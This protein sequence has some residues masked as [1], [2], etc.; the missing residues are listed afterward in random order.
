MSGEC[1]ADP[2]C[3]LLLTIHRVHGVETGRTCIDQCGPKSHS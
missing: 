1:T 3:V 2:E